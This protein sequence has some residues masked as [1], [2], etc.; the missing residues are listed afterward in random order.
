MP[1]P[2]DYTPTRSE[3]EAAKQDLI[4]RQ[5]KEE[6]QKAIEISADRF[7]ADI[8]QMLPHVSSKVL[9]DKFVKYC[10]L[11]VWAE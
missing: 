1:N 11:V 10:E 9:R 3:I 7:E 4:N 8:R 2:C 6:L 5:S